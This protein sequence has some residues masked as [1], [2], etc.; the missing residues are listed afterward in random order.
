MIITILLVIFG[1]LVLGFFRWMNSYVESPIIDFVP[2]PTT[3]YSAIEV[4]IKQV[5]AKVS[6]LTLEELILC[7]YSYSKTELDTLLMQ[8]EHCGPRVFSLSFV[9][10]LTELATE[11][12]LKKLAEDHEQ[13]VV[14]CYAFWSLANQNSD[15]C[16]EL[17]LKGL[18]DKSTFCINWADVRQT[19]EVSQFLKDCVLYDSHGYSMTIEEIQLLQDK[20]T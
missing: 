16:S 9:A 11:N 14:R 10:R 19:Q 17:L 2:P 8:R 20:T 7:L 5:W 15:C 3:D 13:P 12:E 6:N 18:N 1:L 4:E